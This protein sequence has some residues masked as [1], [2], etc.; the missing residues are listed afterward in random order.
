M[1][2]VLAK[3]GSRSS[4]AAVARADLPWRRHVVL[5]DVAALAVLGFTMAAAPI[6]MPARTVW[7][8]FSSNPPALLFKHD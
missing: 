8:P 5:D 7:F 6:S 2:G 1:C 4:A 3:N